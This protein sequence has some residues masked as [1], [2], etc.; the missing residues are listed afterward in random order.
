M[1]AVSR[2]FRP[3]PKTVAKRHA[4]R[5]SLRNFAQSGARGVSARPPA[6]DTAPLE[7]TGPA[8]VLAHD[9]RRPTA[10]DHPSEPLVGPPG[11]PESTSPPAADT[12]APA[13]SQPML[14]ANDDPSALPFGELHDVLPP[15]PT[16]LQARVGGQEAMVAGRPPV[17]ITPDELASHAARALAHDDY[18]NAVA[19]W[20]SHFRQTNQAKSLESLHTVL[21][22][23]GVSATLTR[24]ASLKLF[25]SAET[26]Q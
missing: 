16:P 14:W 19:A 3:S 10:P 23:I 17:S 6:D 15:L 26:V 4:R 22:L 2:H 20:A 21:Q 13:A 5:A 18:L 9:A 25:G 11:A 7:T 1:I 12:H 24:T 8:L